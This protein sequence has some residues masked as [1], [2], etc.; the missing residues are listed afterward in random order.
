M[1]SKF[2]CSVAVALALAGS[3]ACNSCSREPPSGSASIAW[4][5][6]ALGGPATCA[7]AGAASV[8][9]VLRS[10]RG[11]ELHFTFPCADVQGTITPVTAGAYDATLTLYDADGATLAVG[12]TQRAVA[13]GTGQVTTLT[14][15][16]FAVEGGKL[17]LSFATIG[18]S[19]NCFLREQ[20][21]AGITGTTMT[22]ER[23]AGGCAPVT[24][25]RS[26]GDTTIGTYTVN[27]SSPQVTP[28]IERDETLAVDGIE[29]GP[30]VIRVGGLT[31]AV[32]CW[33]GAD[34]LL[35]PAGSSVVKRIEL[36]PNPR[37]GC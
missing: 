12:H 18:T 34:I 4:S 15:V 17:V 13:I 25:V 10:R 29:S 22:L 31:G 1:R 23:G 24:F 28:C 21:G 30:Y 27:C 7:R 6:T 5:I 36:E 16:A 14:P 9:L 11:D 33:A 20:G 3:A 19:T 35:V 2:L 32:Q 8:S 37:V 26:R